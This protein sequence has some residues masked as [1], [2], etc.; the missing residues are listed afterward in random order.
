M[1]PVLTPP[2]HL[3]TG[4]GF[5]GPDGAYPFA[6]KECAR[7]LAKFSTEVAGEHSAAGLRFCACLAA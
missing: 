5:Y 6:G 7:A 3:P 2:P 1:G 4:A